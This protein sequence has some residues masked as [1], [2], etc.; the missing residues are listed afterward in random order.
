MN[1]GLI[2]LIILQVCMVGGCFFVYS[3]F[4]SDK[5]SLKQDIAGLKTDMALISASVAAS[6]VIVE[7][8]EITHYKA[9]QT[10]QLALETEINTYG[11]KIVSLV[12]SQSSLSAKLASRERV[13]KRNATKASAQDAEEAEDGP[14]T[15]AQGLQGV[16]AIPLYA[17]ALPP[18]NNQKNGHN[19]PSHF[20]KKVG[21]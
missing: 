1:Y 3:R 12:E 17:E 16:G 13:E 14:L 4:L 21:T 20:G 11:S 19:I 7:G 5:E 6:K 15:F 8:L 2:A 10:R 9:L 18:L